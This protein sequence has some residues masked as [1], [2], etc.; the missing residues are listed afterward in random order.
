M[1]RGSTL[2]NRNPAST[3][4]GGAH[5]LIEHARQKSKKPEVAAS[6]FLRQQTLALFVNRK[7]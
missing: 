4:D 1:D 7:P 6:G 2:P 5:D 3:S